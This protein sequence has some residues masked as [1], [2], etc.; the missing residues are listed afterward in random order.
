[1]QV[2]LLDLKGQYSALRGEIRRVLDDVCDSQYFIL[3]PRVKA[4]EE[5]VA[6]YCGSR[7]A[8]GVSSGTD[9]L[10][11]SLMALDV[12]P[13]DGVVTTP[14]TFFATGGC[15]A[16]LGATPIFADI[17]PVSYNL[18]PKAVE[19]ALEEC[20][21]RNP[22]VTPTVLLPVHL[23]GQSADM[24]LL[25]AIA[26]DHGLRVIEDACQAI[27]AEYPS[28]TG[29]KRCGTMGDLGCFSFFPSKN[30]GGFGDGG[31]VVTDDDEL[32]EKIRILRNHGA[33]PK[34]YHQ[35]IGG[36]FRLDALQAAVLDVKLAYLDTWHGARQQN[37][38]R[39]DA[40]F[41]GTAVTS[42]AAV[43]ADNGMKYGHIYNQYIIRTPERDA[44]RERLQRREIGNEIYYP[45]PLHLQDC[46]S[47][48]GYTEG[49]FPESES[50]ARETLALPI[51]PE[52]TESMQDAVVKAVLDS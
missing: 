1:M 36:N 2:P 39:Y 4:F 21:F 25:R 13:G 23:Y 16:R 31:M 22:G 27:G 52:L 35:C 42:P 28:A 8:I 6:E 19:K 46:F 15:I 32:V 37:A 10:L 11:V 30:L 5:H 14:Y 18:D 51:Y 34:Y 50:A 12:G 17:D 41:E 20:S 44:V 7:H 43:Y 45:V 48:L 47:S 33:E 3:G 40:A 29:V 38:A 9:A 49:D 26:A 24:D